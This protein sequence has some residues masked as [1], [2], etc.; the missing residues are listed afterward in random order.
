MKALIPIDVIEKKI[1]FLRGQKVILDTDLA[2]LYGVS[3]KR[4]KE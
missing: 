3:T 2:M 4:L 1:L